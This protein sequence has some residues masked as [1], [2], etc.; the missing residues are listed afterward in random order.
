MTL[1]LWLPISSQ[2]SP[3]LF[4]LQFTNVVVGLI[5]VYDSSTTEN[6]SILPVN[7]SHSKAGTSAKNSEIPKIFLNNIYNMIF[8]TILQLNICPDSC[9]LSIWLLWHVFCWFWHVSS[10]SIVTIKIRLQGPP[11]WFVATEAPLSSLSLH[12]LSFC[13]SPATHHLSWIPP[14]LC[15][16]HLN[17]LFHVRS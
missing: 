9:D 2:S 17:L 1:N 8:L 6:A 10:R 4:D 14:R 5:Y 16:C 7:Q 3:A 15:L 13:C 11:F 12:R